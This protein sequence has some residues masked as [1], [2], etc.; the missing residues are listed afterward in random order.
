MVERLPASKST[1][2]SPLTNS[3]QIRAFGSTAS[4]LPTSS[5]SSLYQGGGAGGGGGGGSSYYQH[6]PSHHG[7]NSGGMMAQGMGGL[8]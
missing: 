4:T 2:I 7:G 6:A 3:N 1:H 8:N 5:S